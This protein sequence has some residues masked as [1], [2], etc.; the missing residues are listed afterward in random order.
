MEKNL[1][2]AKQ[3]LPLLKT[4]NTDPIAIGLQ[5]ALNNERIVKRAVEDLKEVL[6]KAMLKVGLRAANMPKDEEKQVLI[7]HILTHYAGH[8]CEEIKLAFDMA[9]AGKLDVEV[10][11]YENFSCLYFSS[12]MN[13]YRKWAKEEIKHLDKPLELPPEQKIEP[14]SDDEILQMSFDVWKALKNYRA[15]SARCYSILIRQGKIKRVEGEER[16]YVIKKAVDDL[17]QDLRESGEVLSYE[18]KESKIND[19]CK[20]LVVQKYFNKLLTVRP[21]QA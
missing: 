16:D 9:I 4:G 5:V 2:P 20:K 6:R 11:C 14:L 8:T 15:I 21:C 18:K 19:M 13:A 17:H 7:E 12:I 10:N 3:E 1:E